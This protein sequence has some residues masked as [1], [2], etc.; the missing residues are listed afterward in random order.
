MC[1]A[2]QPGVQAARRSCRSCA[3]Y[4]RL[5]AALGLVTIVLLSITIALC[6]H[7]KHIHGGGDPPLR[8]PDGPDGG[9]ETDCSPR[10]TSL[11]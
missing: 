8:Q 1:S 4:R 2:V 11:T 7:S 6:V 5:S 10:E 9:S 3:V